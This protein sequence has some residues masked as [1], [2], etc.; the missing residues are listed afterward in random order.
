MGGVRLRL[1]GEFELRCMNEC[2]EWGSAMLRGKHVLLK[3][4]CLSCA[5]WCPLQTPSAPARSCRVC[6]CHNPLAP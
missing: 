2:A 5:A 3:Y 6:A 4:M 1:R